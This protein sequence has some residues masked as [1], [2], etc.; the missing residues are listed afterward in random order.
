[1]EI[2]VVVTLIGLLASIAIPSIQRIKL[3]AVSSTFVSDMRI[4]EEAFQGYAQEFGKF[5]ADTAAGSFQPEW[6]DISMR[7]VGRVRQLWAVIINGMTPDLTL[8]S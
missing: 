2:M 8:E 6:L 5:P 4:M 1:M 7:I 3:R